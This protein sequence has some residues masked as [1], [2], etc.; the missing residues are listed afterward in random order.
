MII[1]YLYV[2][3]GVIL[4]IIG[5]LIDEI[6]WTWILILIGVLMIFIGCLMYAITDGSDDRIALFKDV[7]EKYG[8]N[9]KNSDSIDKK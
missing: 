2:I 4:S 1:I 9:L 6:A 8:I 3:L 7:F 5:I